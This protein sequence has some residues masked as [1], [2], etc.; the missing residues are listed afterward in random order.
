LTTRGQKTRGGRDREARTTEAALFRWFVIA[1][2]QAGPLP[3]LP[4]GERKMSAPFGL[5]RQIGMR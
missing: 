3:L 1:V 5:I 4:R 2:Q